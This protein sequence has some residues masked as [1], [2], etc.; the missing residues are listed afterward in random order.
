LYKYDNYLIELGKI[1]GLKAISALDDQAFVHV[2]TG[3]D[4]FA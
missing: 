2:A 1:N 3:Q 4:I